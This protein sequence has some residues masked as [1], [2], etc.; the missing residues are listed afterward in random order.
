MLGGCTLLLDLD[1]LS[2][3]YAIRKPIDD[4]LRLDAFQRFIDGDMSS[5]AVGLANVREPIAHLHLTASR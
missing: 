4:P 2:L 1:T 3:R 5:A